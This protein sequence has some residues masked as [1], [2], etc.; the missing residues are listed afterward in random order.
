M[1]L[2]EQFAH[3]DWVHTTI[4]PRTI[5]TGQKPSMKRHCRIGFGTYVQVHEKPNSSMEPRTSHQALSPKT[6]LFPELTYLKINT[7]R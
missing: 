5:M 2:A 6:I 1:Y 7:Q 3:R 4:R